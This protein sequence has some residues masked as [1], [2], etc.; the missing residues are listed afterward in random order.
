MLVRNRKILET[1]PLLIAKVCTDK[2]Q[3]HGDSKPQG[4]QSNEGGKGNGSTAPLTPQD[5]IQQE[6]DPKHHSVIQCRNKFLRTSFSNILQCFLI[7]LGAQ[8]V[9]HDPLIK[10]SIFSQ[11]SKTNCML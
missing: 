3:R 10:L 8:N 4:Q 7:F 11:T 1:N 5:E 2:C 9:L 6:E